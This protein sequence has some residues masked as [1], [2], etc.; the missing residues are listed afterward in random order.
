MANYNLYFMNVVTGHIDR[1]HDFEAADHSAAV[2][3]ARTE[4]SPQPMELWCE[5]R[6]IQRFEAVAQPAQTASQG[7]VSR[8]DEQSTV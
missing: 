1:V 2:K 4:Q 3:L 6:K 5:H 8:W 7:L